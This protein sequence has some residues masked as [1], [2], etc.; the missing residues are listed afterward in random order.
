VLGIEVVAGDQTLNIRARKAVILATGGFKANHQMLRSWDPQLDE[1]WT[2]S[3]Y[4]YTHTTGDGHL[5]TQCI[6]GG[7]TDMSFVCE[8]SI[9]LGSRRYVVWDPQSMQTVPASGGLPISDSTKSRIILVE[10]QGQ[11]YVDESQFATSHITLWGHHTEAFLN[12]PERPRNAWAIAD[13]AGAEVLGW[14]LNQFQNPQPTVAPYL[15]PEF[16][17]TGNTLAELATQMGVP[18]ANLEETVTKYNGFVAAGADPDFN[19]PGPLFAI[20]KPPF[21]AAKVALITHDQCAGVRVN[22]RLQVIDQTQQVETGF[23]PSLPLNQER[24]IPHLYAAG[25]VAGGTFGA[26]RGSGKMGS[27]LVQGRFAGKYAAAESVV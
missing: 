4:P 5:A 22:S 7:V 3:G 24:V 27:Y 15:E 6:G 2:W 25:E 1:P 9:K 13:A 26:D 12:L 21:F 14:K 18:V 16:V 19:R 8:F 17:A 23:G 11:R 20:S 10:N